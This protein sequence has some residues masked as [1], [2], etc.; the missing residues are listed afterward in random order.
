MPGSAAHDVRDR[1]H[2]VRR[3]WRRCRGCGPA[4]PRSRS[5]CQP[6]KVSE[7]V[8]VALHLDLEA[9]A[10]GAER[11]GRVEVLLAHQPVDRDASTTG[12]RRPCASHANRCAATWPGSIDADRRRRSGGRDRDLLRAARSRR[13]REARAASRHIRTDWTKPP[14]SSRSIGP[15]IASSGVPPNPM[16]CRARTSGARRCGCRRTPRRGRSVTAEHSAENMSGMQ[17]GDAAGVDAGA[18]QRRAA[19]RQAASMRPRR[20]RARGRTSRPA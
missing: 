18:V 15:G 14:E 13:R 7:R 2:A 10:L 12:V 6:W 20:G 9:L 19:R 11:P 5:G 8:R 3:R 1:V 17:L 4:R 16:M